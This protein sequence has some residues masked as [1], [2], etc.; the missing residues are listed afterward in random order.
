MRYFGLL[1]K[2]STSP[3]SA[4]YVCHGSVSS[5]FIFWIPGPELLL[6]SYNK[7]IS[8]QNCVQLQIN[9]SP[10][11]QTVQQGVIIIDSGSEFQVGL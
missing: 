6:R 7:E 9:F 8:K 10:Q 11:F 1:F 4:V 5:P 3:V 2:A